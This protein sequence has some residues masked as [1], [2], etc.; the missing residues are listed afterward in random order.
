MPDPYTTRVGLRKLSQDI[1]SADHGYNYP[2][3]LDLKPGNEFHD[4]LVQR[5]LERG[6]ASYN[7]MSQSYHNWA[8]LDRKLRAYVPAGRIEARR[9][10]EKKGED[11]NFSGEELVIPVSYAILQAHMT[12][13]MK[14]FIQSPV[15][16]YQ[17]SGPEDVVGAKILEFV[18]DHQ[19]RQARMGIPLIT[20][21][22]DGF[23][24]GFSALTPMWEK[25]STVQRRVALEGDTDLFGNFV[26]ERVVRKRESVAYEGHKLRSVDP[27]RFLPDPSVAVHDIHE[28]EFVGW[29]RT[30]SI[31]NLLSAEK[32]DKH[33]FNV[34]YAHMMQNKKST[35]SPNEYRTERERST[36]TTSG[37]AP[38]GIIDPVDTLTIY[39]KVIPKMWKL[40]NSQ[41]PEIWMFEI[42]G[43]RIIT[44]ARPLG[45]DHGMF[46]VVTS[47]PDFDGYSANPSSRL[48]ITQDLQEIIDFLYTSRIQNIRKSLV[49]QYV[50]DPYLVHT[51]D[52]ANPKPGKL[53]RLRKSV[54]GK[55]AVSNAVAQLPVEDVTAGH[56]QE[57]SFVGELMRQST[58]ANDQLLGFIAPRTSRI[59]ANEVQ[60]A[61][62][63]GLSRLE[64][65]ATIISLQ[66]MLP[67]GRMLASQTIQLMPD[68]VYVRLSQGVSD[69]VREH[70]A[71]STVNDFAAV[72]PFDLSVNYDVVESDGTVPGSQDV[73]SWLTLYSLLAENPVLSQEVDML[74]IFQNIARELGV[75]NVDDLIRPQQQQQTVA[76]DEEVESQVQAGNLVPAEEAAAA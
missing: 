62:T 38:A 5:L 21:F 26:E 24:Y 50:V 59:S 68:N 13:M 36:Y 22:R 40:G 12:Y 42:A 35:L 37:Q 48:S 1:K 14:A 3:D 44:Q 16:R 32:N 9:A 63:S 74:K 57:V 70:L 65:T 45:L 53:I 34:R 4:Q 28:G 67:L 51:G 39:I 6:K 46:P 69:Q 18:I 64:A 61:R 43:D 30:T 66:Q 23:V 25:K 41:Y 75:R 20:S 56:T 29:T 11:Y 17:G 52:L 15:F 58:G 27:Y 33:I 31:M 49:G 10:A 72:S 73:E 60:G 7:V 76:P 19:F 47:A 54:W 2:R 71:G 55:V 8:E